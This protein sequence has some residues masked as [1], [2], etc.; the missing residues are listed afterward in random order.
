LGWGV[1]EEGEKVTV[2]PGT[3]GENEPERATSPLKGP[4]EVTVRVMSV[5]EACTMVIAVTDVDKLKS[6]GTSVTTKTC[7]WTG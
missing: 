4:I 2:R 5:R 1:T 7:P 3:D 6:R